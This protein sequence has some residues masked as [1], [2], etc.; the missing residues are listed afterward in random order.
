MPVS[1]A[2]TLMSPQEE[3]AAK[4]MAHKGYPKI[5]PTDVGKVDG[6]PCWYFTYQLP[7]GRLELEVEHVDGDWKFVSYMD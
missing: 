3:A 4:Y 5:L 6:I 7:E 1:D 2:R